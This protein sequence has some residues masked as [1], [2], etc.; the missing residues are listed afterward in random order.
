MLRMKTITV[1]L[2]GFCLATACSKKEAAVP[3]TDSTVAPAPAPAPSVSSIEI[4]RKLGANNAVAEPATV[5]GKRDTI[6]ASVTAQNVLPSSSLTAKW[7]FQTG[8]L[9]D[10]TTQ[11]VA[12]TDAT[13]TTTVTEF[14]ISKKTPWPA[15]NYKVE[16]W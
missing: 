4:G 7:T 6:Y 3:A 10:S 13:N 11:A 15:G 5:F 8:Q 1:G 12:R 14:H 16:I 2:L 9:V